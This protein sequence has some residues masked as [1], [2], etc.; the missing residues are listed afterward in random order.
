MGDMQFEDQTNEFGSPRERASGFDL[1]GALVRW[2]LVSTPQ[3]AQYALIAVI[4]L[5]A[6]IA[7]YFFFSSG[8]STP[9]PPP[10]Y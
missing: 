7:G 10:V 6:L 2:G 8:G 5:S 3:E 4:V 9:P 1:S